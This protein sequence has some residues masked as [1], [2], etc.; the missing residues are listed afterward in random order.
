MMDLTKY[1]T[2]IDEPVLNEFCKNDYVRLLLELSAKTKLDVL[3]KKYKRWIIKDKYDII[4]QCKKIKRKEIKQTMNLLTKLADKI[5]PEAL[6]EIKEL[7]TQLEDKINDIN[8]IIDHIS[9]SEE[10]YIECY[11]NC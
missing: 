1:Y 3:Q 6:S 5:Q 2:S 8:M 11:S 4:T 9:S 10:E 7:N